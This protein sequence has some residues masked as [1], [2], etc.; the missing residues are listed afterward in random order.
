MSMQTDCIYG[1]GSPIHV[2]DENLAKFIKG[3]R[4]VLEFCGKDEKR[5]LA[6]VDEHDCYDGISEDL[7]DYQAD[8]SD[9]GIYG[10]VAKV[11]EQQTGIGFEYRRETDG[12]NP[13][14]YILLP[15]RLPW[16]Y[17]PQERNL[18]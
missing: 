12:D 1:F 10:I 17:N 8:D 7:F 16:Q 18:T 5:L 9:S 2:A 3:H 6:Y 14:E 15:E 4:D 13:E 11:M